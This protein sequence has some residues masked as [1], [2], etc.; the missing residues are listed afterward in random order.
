MRRLLLITTIAACG[1]IAIPAAAQAATC[2][3]TGAAG[4]WSLASNWDCGGMAV[5]PTGADSVTLDAA[6]SVVVDAA[7]S[8]AS[9][10]ITGGS[11]SIASPITLTTPSVT[12]STGLLTGDGTLSG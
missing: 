5:V 2:E 10:T 6:D 7:A 12:L 4:N 11:L 8:A 9:V 3:F 1:A